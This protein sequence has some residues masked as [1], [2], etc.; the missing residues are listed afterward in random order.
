VI[1]NAE[2]LLLTR[3]ILETSRGLLVGPDCPPGL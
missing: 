2:N 3:F 1:A